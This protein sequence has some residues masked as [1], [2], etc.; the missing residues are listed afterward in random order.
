MKDTGQRLG[1]Q[2]LSRPGRSDHEDIALFEV[3]VLEPFPVHN[4]FIV[5]VN[6]NGEDF[7]GPILPDHIFI[8]LGFNIRGLGD[9]Q[10]ERRGCSLCTARLIFGKRQRTA[11]N[12]FFTNTNLG[13]GPARGAGEGL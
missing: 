13:R 8:E 9:N 10:W 7:L 12:T 11:L 1:Q 3:D 4:P 2:R 6:G 5:I